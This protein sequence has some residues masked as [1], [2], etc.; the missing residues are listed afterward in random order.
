MRDV[1]GIGVMTP[2][3][4]FKTPVILCLSLFC[5]VELENL[6]SRSIYQLRTFR[7]P[8]F[9]IFLYFILGCTGDFR[10]TKSY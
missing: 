3:T 9:F 1:E 7:F 8:Y 4:E 10:N 6:H 5:I 2:G